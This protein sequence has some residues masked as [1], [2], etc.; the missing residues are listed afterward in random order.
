MQNFDNFS[1]H[2]ASEVLEQATDC[3]LA[4]LNSTWECE[5]LCFWLTVDAGDL[6]IWLCED[7]PQLAARIWRMN[8]LKKYKKRIAARISL[9]Q[10]AEGFVWKHVDDALRTFIADSPTG[11]RLGMVRALMEKARLTFSDDHYYWDDEDEETYVSYLDN[12]DGADERWRGG[13]PGYGAM[14]TEAVA[15]EALRIIVGRNI[16]AIETGQRGYTQQSNSW[17]TDEGCA[18]V[19][20]IRRCAHS[21]ATTCYV[22]A[23]DALPQS[24]RDRTAEHRCLAV[25]VDDQWLDHPEL[26]ANPDGLCYHLLDDGDNPIPIPTWGLANKVL[27]LRAETFLEPIRRFRSALPVLY[28]GST[29]CRLVIHKFAHWADLHRLIDEQRKDG[30]RPE[31]HESIDMNSLTTELPDGTVLYPSLKRNLVDLTGG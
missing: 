13:G 6:F 27:W 26:I 25:E 18:I 15:R 2:E 20:E 14:V 31:Y 10:R 17:E 12:H 9:M 19:D 5:T 30:T 29:R 16:H 22:V 4:A 21:S 8:L 7:Q 11:E 28:V 23:E 3:S 24:L 1:S